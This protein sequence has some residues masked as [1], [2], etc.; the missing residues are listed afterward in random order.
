MSDPNAT[1]PSLTNRRGPEGNSGND[2]SNEEQIAEVTP[3]V[4]PW[5]ERKKF[6]SLRRK[7]DEST[8]K[9]LERIRSAAIDCEFGSQLENIIMDKFITKL[10]GKAFDRISEEETGK[11]TLEKAIELAM[12][13][14]EASDTDGAKTDTRERCK[15]CGYKGHVG[16]KC[17]WR[18]AQCHKCG[19]T[20]H[21]AAICKTENAV[22]T[23][24]NGESNNTANP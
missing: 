10:S 23:I 2:N 4:N 14:D 8:V 11:L 6:Y 20:G 7:N 9:W 13:F 15:H 21:L 5:K 22:N 16:E 18:T 1:I 24:S 17:K 19:V 12:K 3:R